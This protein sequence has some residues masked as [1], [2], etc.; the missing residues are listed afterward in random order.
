MFRTGLLIAMAVALVGGTASAAVVIEDFNNAAI[1]SYNA[2][3][4]NKATAGTAKLTG[5]EVGGRYFMFEDVGGDRVMSATQNYGGYDVGIH[6]TAQ[7]NEYRPAWDAAQASEA[8]VLSDAEELLFDVAFRIAVAGRPN[9]SFKVDMYYFDVS[10][11]APKTVTILAPPLTDWEIDEIKTF[12]VALDTI[13]DFDKSVDL[14]FGF[15]M[16]DVWTRI[17]LTYGAY[18]LA[19]IQYT[20]VPEPTTL[21]LLSGA[22]LAGALRRR[23]A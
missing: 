8:L 12:S 3:G 13:S 9:T 23:W 10:D 19:S 20:A 14:V 5:W 22:A 18:G 17:G 6:L 15:R 1:E 11:N 2:Y 7:S 21:L 16:S 4:G